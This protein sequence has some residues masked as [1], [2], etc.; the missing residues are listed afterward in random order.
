MF[1][2]FFSTK[3]SNLFTRSFHVGKSFKVSNPEDIFFHSICINLRQR[4]WTVLDKLLSSNLTN[5]LVNR[6]VSEFRMSPDLA[7]GFYNKVEE[8]RDFSPSLEC[9]CVLIH[10]MIRCK[11]YDDG[12]DLIGKLIREMGYSHLEVL[13]G[14]WD[15]YNAE[16]SCPNV[17]DALVRGCTLLGDA[18]C[19]YDVIVKLR[20]EKGFIV[21]VHAWNNFFSCLIKSDEVSCFWRKYGEMISYGHAENVYTFN[22]VIHALCKEMLVSEAI[23]V[24][25]RMLKGGIYPNVVTFNMIIDGACKMGDVGLGLKLFRKMELMSRGIVMPNLVTFNCL[26]N[27]YCKLGDMETVESLR[28]EMMVIGI[29]PNV[30]TYATLID[31]YLRKGCT[32]EAFGLCSHMVDNGLI[33]NVVIYN[34]MIHWLYFEGDTT[35]A[36]ILLSYMIKSNI[37]FDKFTNSVLIKGLSRNGYLNEA[38]DYHKWLVAKNLVDKDRFLENILVYYLFRS[39]NEPMVKQVLDDMFGRGLSADTVTYGTM[40][41][42]FSKQGSISYAVRVY[43]DMIKMGKKPNLIIYNSIVDGLSKNLSVDIAKIMVDELKKIGLVDVVTLNSLLNGYC[44]NWK[45]KEALTLFLQMQEDGKLVNRVTYNILMNFVC[46]FVSIQEA[47]ELME[48]MVA[49]GVAP[50]SVTYT[51]L[52]MNACKKS[53]P[54][55]VIDIH[56]DM[57][58]KGVIP[59]R[60]TYDAIVGPL[61]G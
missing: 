44:T 27:G 29:E 11:R 20:M 15:S 54:E 34:S 48:M 40:I 16:I 13:D 50:D 57:V 55:E 59:N 58:I 42:A 25:Y 49:Q 7:L 41:D 4:K 19:A 17:F 5:S 8:Q 24:F 39:D 30:M 36:S 45:V 56:D 18:N 31:G 53:S 1:L 23:G 22:L 52:L 43:D 10:V 2:K 9:V 6:V 61:L 46:K 35:T 38:L 47:K 26:I 51:I 3:R 32:K 28:D 60:K 14:L 12:L 21:S 33:P 37:C